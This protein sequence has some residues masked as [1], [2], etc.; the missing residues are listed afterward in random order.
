MIKTGNLFSD[1]PSNMKQEVSESLLKNAAIQIERIVSKGHASPP[2]FWYDQTTHEW[3]VVLKGKARLIFEDPYQV[4]EMTPG[5]YIDIPAGCRH[6]V[7]WTD[8]SQ[9]TI[10]V[11]MHF[12]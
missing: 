11:A 9:E 3:V 2:G 4:I 6:R 1:I 12:K 7:D 5:D 10:W 8:P